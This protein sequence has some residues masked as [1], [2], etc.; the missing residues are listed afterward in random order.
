MAI[1]APARERS[2]SHEWQAGHWST[3]PTFYT[4]AVVATRPYKLVTLTSNFA[5]IISMLKKALIII[6]L[7]SAGLLLFVINSTTPSSVG[8]EGLLGV[9]FLTYLVTL[10]V[11]TLLLWTYNF[12]LWRTK[13]AL[14]SN[15][16]QPFPSLKKSYYFG[17]I[18]SLG[19]VI[20][21]GVQSV[22]GLGWYEVVLVAVFLILGCFYIGRRVV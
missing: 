10:S 13:R 19:P 17:S 1:V 16:S 2:D 21:L 4:A 22:N 8:A 14:N 7:V 5:I 20:L 6:G 12:L 9:F 15:K 3:R 18:L 11:V